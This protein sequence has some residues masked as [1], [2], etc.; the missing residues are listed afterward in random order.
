MTPKGRGQGH[1]TYFLILGPLRNFWTGEARHFVFSL[2]DRPRRIV[3]DGDEKPLRGRVHHV[4]YFFKF[5]DIERVKVNTSFF[6]C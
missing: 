5:W 1:V 6:L 2:L 3:S 4:T